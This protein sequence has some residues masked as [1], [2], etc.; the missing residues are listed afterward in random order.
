M[1][2]GGGMK[3][4]SLGVVWYEHTYVAVQ[5]LMN[6]VQIYAYTLRDDKL[7]SHSFKNSLFHGGLQFPLS[8]VSIFITH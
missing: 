6:R 4:I 8:R 2:D 1:R 5:M 7:R 3:K